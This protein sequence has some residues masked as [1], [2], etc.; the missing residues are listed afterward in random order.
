MFSPSRYWY[1]YLPSAGSDH[2]D[3]RV[4][5]R[6]RGNNIIMDDIYLIFINNF[7]YFKNHPYVCFLY[8]DPLPYFFD[9]FQFRHFFFES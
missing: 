1:R 4:A 9:C 6:V 8:P 2:S 5:S 3:F 7:A